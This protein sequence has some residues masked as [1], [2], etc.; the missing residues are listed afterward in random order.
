MGVILDR[1]ANSSMGHGGLGAK[2]GVFEKVV[3]QKQIEAVRLQRYIHVSIFTHDCGV[4]ADSKTA[5]LL[6]ESSYVRTCLRVLCKNRRVH[7]DFLQ[8]FC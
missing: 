8:G 5:F 1:L 2:G 3:L 4:V 6:A 7:V